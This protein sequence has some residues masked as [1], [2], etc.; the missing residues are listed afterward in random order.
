M[1]RLAVVTALACALAGRLGAQDSTAVVLQRAR[2]LYEGVELERAL[3]LLRAIVSPSWTFDVTQ[4]QRVE[5]NLYL[6]ATLVLLGARDSG[7]VHFRAALRRDPFADLDPTRFTPAQIDAFQS[8]RR[9]VFAVGVRP[10]APTR[11]DPRTGRMSFTV[12]TTHTAAVG[13]EIRIENAATTFVLFTGDI[14][15]LRELEWDGT[16]PNGQLA[17]SGRYALVLRARSRIRAASDSSRTYFD[18]Q[19]E[20]P[21]LEDTLADLSPR[22]LLPEGYPRSARTGD[23]LKGLGVAAGALFLADVAGNGRLGRSRGMAVVVGTA[24]LVAGITSFAGRGERSRPDNIAVNERRRLARGA[25]NAQIG[26]RNAARLAQTILNI[27]PAA[28][29]GH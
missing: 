11:L 17:P 3:P 25:A 4:A 13:C 8:A 5:A 7:V 2:V 14:E 21:A 26:R 29:S 9:D 24:G 1:K 27:T 12:V 18:V 22:E 20:F 15:G 19:Q 16:L 6:G 23:L 28:G 10:V